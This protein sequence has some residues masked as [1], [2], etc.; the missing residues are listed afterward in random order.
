MEAG[1]IDAYRAAEYVVFDGDRTFT[2]RVGQV[3]Q[4]LKLL[5]TQS[6][7]SSAAFITAYNPYSKLHAEDFNH[8]ANLRLLQELRQ[9][10]SLILNG[11][12]QDP[13]GI[14][15]SEQSFLTL[16]ISRGRASEIGKTFMQNAFL[17]IGADARPE[18]V[19]LTCFDSGN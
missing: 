19:R 7:Q 18:L 1:L 11:Q 13:L 6:G 12:G 8:L 5:F 16:G 10:T 3:S 9:C 17:W 2:L 4:E 14:W 15:H